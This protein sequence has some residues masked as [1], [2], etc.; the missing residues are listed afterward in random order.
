MS[1]VNRKLTSILA[2]DC[3]GFSSLME[4]NEE[5]T[6]ITNKETKKEN[7]SSCLGY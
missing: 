6:D 3:F 4:K 2:A 7:A 5:Q 1:N